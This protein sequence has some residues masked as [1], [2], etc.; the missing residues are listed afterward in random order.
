MLVDGAGYLATIV[1]AVLSH[2]RG[3]PL[4]SPAR[5]DVFNVKID[6]V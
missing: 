5:E 2:R 4:C 1:L 3:Q 6:R